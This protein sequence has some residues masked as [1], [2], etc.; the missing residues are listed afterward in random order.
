MI[1]VRTLVGGGEEESTSLFLR[2]EM[3]VEAAA[4]EGIDIEQWKK[5]FRAQESNK[6]EF[7]KV[8][9]NES[10]ARYVKRRVW[11]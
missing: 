9:D 2:S 7:E 3:V 10:W 11:S 4:Q 5:V 1:N 8:S 6:E